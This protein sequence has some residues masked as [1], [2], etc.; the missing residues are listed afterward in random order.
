MTVAV[1]GVIALVVAA[2]VFTGATTSGRVAQNARSLH[3]ANAMLGSSEIAR[4]AVGQAVLVA[5][6]DEADPE[7]TAAALAEARYALDTA[8]YW[9]ARPEADVVRR[10]GHPP[11]R[12]RGCHPRNAQQR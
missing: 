9:A 5:G 11:A 1:L 12:L 3:W 7:Q 8:R 2:I 10:W 6:D 4:L